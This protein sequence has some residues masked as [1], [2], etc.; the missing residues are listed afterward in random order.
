MKVHIFKDIGPVKGYILQYVGRP[1]T[2]VDNEH[3]LV[4]RSIF[5]Q[6]VGYCYVKCYFGW[7]FVYQLH[8][9]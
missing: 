1:T 4:N 3:V 7:G 9:G 6:P 5:Y 8:F 2:T